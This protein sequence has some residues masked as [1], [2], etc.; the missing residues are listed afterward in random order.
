MHR[1]A[2]VLLLVSCG[3]GTG[4]VQI[5]VTPEGTISDGLAAGPGEDEINDGWTVTYDKFLVSIGDVAART[6][7]GF[8]LSD[9]GRVY[10]SDL[11]ALG[12]DGAIFATWKDALAERYQQFSYSFRAAA[13]PERTDSISDADYD[14]MIQEKYTLYVTGTIAKATG[15]SC[16]PGGVCRPAPRIG[17]ALGYKGETL[18][19]ACAAEE[20][21]PSGFAVTDRGTVAVKPTIHGDH[22]F[23]T[24][25]PHATTP[26]RLAQWLANADRDGDDLVT[27]SE[28]IAS[29]NVAA[30]F[31]P[32]DYN[33]S[34]LPVTP[35]QNAF[36]YFGAMART[37]GHFNG[38][39][40]CEDVRILSTD[41]GDPASLEVDMPPK[42]STYTP[43]NY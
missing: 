36:H 42:D 43:K 41:P 14:L 26:K 19:G 35:I 39:G 34:G 17:F 2:C 22:W 30:L 12:S 13:S 33:L 8:V 4:A 28:L 6:N 9:D 32:A 10:L 24:S 29:T 1:L 3:S 38:D 5:F 40:H 31:P 23:F 25:D 21:G 37:I 20:G 18:F 15:E 16:P 11:K 27:T 7:D